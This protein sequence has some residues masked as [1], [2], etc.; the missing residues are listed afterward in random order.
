M[1]ENTLLK[2]STILNKSNYND[3][4]IITV[5]NEMNKI[6]NKT[7]KRFYKTQS[8]NSYQ[9][10]LIL[11]IEIIKKLYDIIE[12]NEQYHSIIKI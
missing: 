8:S 10:D 2:A 9:N 12:N 5:Y 11:Y 1:S 3:N 6:N 7:L 4:E